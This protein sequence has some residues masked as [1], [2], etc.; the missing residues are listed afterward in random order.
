MAPPPAAARRAR[1]TARPRRAAAL[2]VTLALAL[3]GCGGGGDDGA[4]ERTELTVLAAASLTDVF[5]TAGDAYQEAHPGTSVRFSFAGSQEVAAQVRQ[6]APAD[7]VATA[8][9][10]TMDGLR[11][12]TGDPALFARNR[13]VVAVADGNPQ[14]VRGLR[15]LERNGL[16]V[17]LAAPEVPVGRYSR[18]V[19]ERQGIA[20]DPVSREPNVRAV[21]SKVELG[22]ADAGIVYRT[23][24]ATAEDTTDTVRIPDRQN[25]LAA[26]PA[27]TLDASA[28]PEAAAAFVRW[29]NGSA[30]QRILRDAGFE[31]P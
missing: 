14:K 17:V 11:G 9:T 1:Q 2:G 6:G 24:A 21:L 28:H 19:L 29:L 20:V 31:A 25:A 13:L 4:G 15:D 12:E 30:A 27:A 3:A 8:D 23:D 10:R 18:R 5:R 16:T 26:Y 7:V 22:E